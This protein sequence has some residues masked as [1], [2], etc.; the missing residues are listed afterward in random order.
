MING[1]TNPGSRSMKANFSTHV[2]RGGIRPAPVVAWLCVVLCWSS[3]AAGAGIKADVVLRGGT[4]VDGTGNPPYRADLALRDGRIAAIGTFDTGS[5]TRS[6]DCSGLVV[7]PGF[8]DLHNHSDESIL[9]PATRL[10]SC[11]LMQGCT[12][13]VTGNCGGGHLQ[14]GEYYDK[15]DQYGSGVNIAHLIPHGTLRDRVM[16]K[17]RRPADADEVRRMCALAN[18]GMR[19]G[20]WGMSTGLQY[21]PGC[22]ASTDELAAIA[23]VVGKCGGLYAS[24]IRDEG[25]RL[26]ESVQEAIDIGRRG[27]VR[28]HISHFKASKRR[29][30]GK[31]RAA[32][33]I[34]DQARAAGLLVTADQYPYNASSTSIRAMLLPDDEREGGETAV[35]ARLNNPAQAARLR[36]I[37][38]DALDARGR[39][40]I[41]GFESRPDWVGKTIRDVAAQEDR[42]AVD[43]A[44]ELLRSGGAQ[45]INFSMD[46]GDV[47]FV[48]TLPWVATASDGSSR[49]DDGTRPH[50]RSYGTFPRKI[51]YYAIRQN[52]LSLAA[53]VRSAT[54][55]PADILGLA[56]RGYL[57][58]DYAADVVVFDPD[59]YGDR[60]TFQE[61]FRMPVGVRWV[62]VNGTA[63]VADGELRP[64]RAGRALRRPQAAREG[65]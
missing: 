23:T 47:R 48:M 30:W 34:I 40:M 52:V 39:L 32:A 12:L 31:V 58:K 43:I 13:L 50:P 55:L 26:V 15:L 64:V 25:D 27:R 57:R 28:V 22:Y 33:R 65:N 21:V 59:E 2:T 11:Y 56:D 1:P 17:G 3:A 42:P 38:S 20:A 7:T 5:G 62:L 10:A 54:G 46:E 6:I 36:P 44:M 8:I 4:I 53:A 14:V 29:N 45:G 16:G 24:H 60:A 18:A 51:G 35:I 19:Q 63:A 9:A 61:P 49:I 37:V 41:A